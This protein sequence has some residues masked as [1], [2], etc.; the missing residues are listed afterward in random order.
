MLLCFFF[1][2]NTAYEMRIGDWSSDVC[3][4]DLLVIRTPGLRLDKIITNGKIWSS[5]NEFFLKCPAPIIGVTGTKGKGTTS[6]LITSILR[7]AGRT[8]HLVGNID[9]KSVV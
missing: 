7:A 9:R 3:S 6:S 1:K 5:T 2:Q 8:V 4:S